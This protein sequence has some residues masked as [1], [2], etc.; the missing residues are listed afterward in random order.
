MTYRNISKYDET[1]NVQCYAQG[2]VA[3]SG[4][5]V[6]LYKLMVNA[7]FTLHACIQGVSR[8]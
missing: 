3:T 7:I 8:L 1:E 4:N 5:S 6:L 2:N